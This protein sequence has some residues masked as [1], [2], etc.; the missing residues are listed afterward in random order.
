MTSGVLSTISERALVG[1]TP[2]AG[3]MLIGHCLGISDT[4]PCAYLSGSLNWYG[5]MILASDIS[6]PQYQHLETL[7][8]R[9]HGNDLSCNA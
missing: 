6:R 9:H 2:V 8:L 5:V 4:P 7:I 1:P 3:G